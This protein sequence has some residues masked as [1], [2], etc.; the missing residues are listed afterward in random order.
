MITLQQLHREI[1][2]GKQK[3]Y[4]DE[5]NNN[6]YFQQIILQEIQHKREK[7]APGST[8]SSFSSFIY[9]RGFNGYERN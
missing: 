9:S 5:K 4:Q 6:I 8:F 1:K 3:I 7:D 2:T